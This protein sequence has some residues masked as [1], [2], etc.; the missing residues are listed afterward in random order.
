M[1]EGFLLFA[2]ALPNILLLKD[3]L[4]KSQVPTKSPSIA[5]ANQGTMRLRTFYRLALVGATI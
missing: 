4:T 2:F 5:D 1:D 3:P